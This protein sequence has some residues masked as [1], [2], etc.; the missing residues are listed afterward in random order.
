M[1]NNCISVDW[2]CDAPEFFREETRLARKPYRCCECP[3]TIQ[4]G[5]LHGYA[6]GKWDGCVTEFRTCARCANVA[7]D[8]FSGRTFGDM[9]EDF[10][11][12]HGFDYRDGIPAD[13]A[14]CR[15]RAA[16]MTPSERRKT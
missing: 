13:F 7:A 4:P 5:D 9:Y 14:P 11:Q 10:F 6:I 16:P 1:S 8:Y 12:A 2:D 3:E 15:E